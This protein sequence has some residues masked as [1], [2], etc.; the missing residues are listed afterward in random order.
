MGDCR[1]RWVG[2]WRSGGVGGGR[3]VSG[4]GE[5]RMGSRPNRLKFFFPL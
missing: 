2:G 5:E 3:G 4:G 1:G